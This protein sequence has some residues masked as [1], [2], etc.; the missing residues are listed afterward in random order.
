MEKSM[1]IHQFF[2]LKQLVVYFD[3]VQTA[4]QDSQFSASTSLTV[5]K[6]IILQF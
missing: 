3:D 2:I 4:D 5:R 6:T 1:H